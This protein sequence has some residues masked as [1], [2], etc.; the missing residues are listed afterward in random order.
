M[1]FIS[2]YAFS[3]FL[4]LSEKEATLLESNSLVNTHG[5]DTILA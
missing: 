5:I 1:I 4:L 2:S 3:Y